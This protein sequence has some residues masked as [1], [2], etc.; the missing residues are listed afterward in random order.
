[1]EEAQRCI[2][3]GSKSLFTEAVLKQ[4]GTLSKML[5]LHYVQLRLIELP[6][7][8]QVFGHVPKYS[9]Y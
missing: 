5:M 9:T 6:L 3:I 2:G 4:Y 8:S 1:M 7:V